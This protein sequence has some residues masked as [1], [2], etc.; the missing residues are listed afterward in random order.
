MKKFYHLED[1]DDSKVWANVEEGHDFDFI[2][3][4]I[5]DMPLEYPYKFKMINGH[6]LDYTPTDTYTI[7]S[8]K[9]KKIVDKFEKN[10]E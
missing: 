9:L 6:F 4:K 7:F 10:L 3:E 2:G 5:Y 1:E 8:E